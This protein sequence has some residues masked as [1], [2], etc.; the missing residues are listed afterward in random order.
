M[1]QPTGSSN[2]V[3]LCRHVNTVVHTMLRHM[4]RLNEWRISAGNLQ[5]F[6]NSHG[7]GILDLTRRM[8]RALW[9]LPKSWKMRLSKTRHR[10]GHHC[11]LKVATCLHVASATVL[12]RSRVG[13]ALFAK[14]SSKDSFAHLNSEASLCAVR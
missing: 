9:I 7:R 3:P 10:L 14:V 5:Y 13:I 12:F 6:P 11:R 4:L 8:H 1:N 2:F